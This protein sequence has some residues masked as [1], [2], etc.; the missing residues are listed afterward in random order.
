MSKKDL[1]NE[2]IGI[3]AFIV[4]VVVASVGIYFYIKHQPTNELKD[5]SNTTISF[6]SFS[7]STTKA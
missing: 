2:Y 7:N 5:M 4:I 6:N 1:I 3:I